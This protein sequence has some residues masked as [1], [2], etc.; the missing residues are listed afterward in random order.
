MT[1][2]N[3]KPEP[4]A[5]GAAS[6]TAAPR[7]T[8][9]R[10]ASKKSE[11][12]QIKEQELRDARNLSKIMGYIGKMSPWGRGELLVEIEKLGPVQPPLKLP[13]T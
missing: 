12:V 11:R 10:G 2:K 13:T 4:A 7:Q 1:A 3:D 9:I 8:R 6:A 5:P